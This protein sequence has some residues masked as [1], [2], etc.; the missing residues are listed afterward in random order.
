MNQTLTKEGAHRLFGELYRYSRSPEL[1][2]QVDQIVKNNKDVFVRIKLIEDLDKKD[3]SKV[4]AFR[5]E[6]VTRA[7]NTIRGA[8]QNTVSGAKKTDSHQALQKDSSSRKGEEGDPSHSSEIQ[9]LR[10]GAAPKAKKGPGFFK[11]LFGGESKRIAA[12]GRDTHTLQ[13]GLFQLT[14]SKEAQSIFFGLNEKSIIETVKALRLAAGG[15]WEHVGALNYNTVI[16]AYQFF[17]EYIKHENIFSRV[18]E[19]EQWIEN[20]IGMQKS[21]AQLLC[22]KDYKNLLLHTLP[23]YIGSNE[24]YSSLLSGLKLS[25]EHIILLSNQRPNLQ[26]TITAFYVLAENRRYA[27]E[28][29]EEKLGVHK[30]INSRFCAPQEVQALIQQRI[31]NLKNKHKTLEEEMQEIKLIRKKYLALKE[32]GSFNSNFLD[33]LI[34]DVVRRAYGEKNAVAHVVR[35]YKGQPHRLLFAV[36]RDFNVNYLPLLGS[37]FLVSGSDKVT[38]TVSLFSPN[39][40]RER[41]ET[42]NQL[43]RTM[44]SYLRKYPGLSYSFPNFAKD[45][46][47]KV[48]DPSLEMLHRIVQ[49]ANEFF[50]DIV[51]DIQTVLNNHE[52]AQASEGIEKGKQTQKQQQQKFKTIEEIGNQARHLPYVDA[53]LLSSGRLND[54]TLHYA[55]ENLATHLYNYLYIFHDSTMHKLVYNSE[56]RKIRKQKLEMQLQRLEARET[57]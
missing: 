8:A 2:K 16:A 40:F 49:Q 24:K 35:S 48:F 1:Q 9:A 14:L 32:D 11:R 23:N 34:Y 45:L 56:E 3:T 47:R 50:K 51:M 5:K 53:K 26:D 13:S 17:S 4:K 30:A 39:V 19:V 46:Q 36:L 41:I 6:P 25:M 33:H 52:R 42:F 57:E 31:Q 28:E 12:W 54:R 10:V 20:T 37:S 44:D 55:V 21:Y 29:I 18:A 22:Y 27:W 15:I 43:L 7:R 38:E